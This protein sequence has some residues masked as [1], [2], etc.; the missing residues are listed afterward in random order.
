MK[1]KKYALI[2]G[3]SK[4]IG[5][6]IAITLA[7]EGVNIFINYLTDQ[8]GALSTQKEIL[9]TGV[10]AFTFK[11][12][13]S[14]QRDMKQMFQHISDVT[15]HL[16]ILVNNA[17][18][19]NDLSIEDYPISEMKRVIDINLIGPMITTKLA[20]PFL[21][22]APAGQIINIGSR[23][24]YAKIIEGVGAYAPSKAGLIR[25]TKCCALEFCNFNIRTNIV[26]PGFTDTEI[27]R[28]F[29]PDKKFWDNAAANNP[30]G[31]VGTPQDVANTVAFLASPKASY[32]NGEIIGVNG[33]SNLV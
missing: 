7:N 30:S 15:K 11:G 26:C 14:N 5:R 25:F 33:G 13:V 16:D 17:G 31:R 6:S 23:M 3:A 24:G 22:N 12:D 29:Y 1:S 28:K 8:K 10:K 2:T 19:D 9:K 21:K 20:L 4:G 32:I 27:T 18:T